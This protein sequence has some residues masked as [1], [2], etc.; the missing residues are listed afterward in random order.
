MT[1]DFRTTKRRWI[2]LYPTESLQG[3]IRYQLT[4][5]ERGVWYD[6][7]CFS[8]LCS[9]SGDISDRDGNPFPTSYIAN[10]LNIQPSLLKNTLDKCKAEGRIKEDDHGLHIV[11][12]ARYQSEYDRQKAFRHKLEYTFEMFCEDYDAL[13][14]HKKT[15]GLGDDLATSRYFWEKYGWSK[16]DMKG[17]RICRLFMATFNVIT[18]KDEKED[19]RV[20]RETLS[21]LQP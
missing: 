2:K 12:W 7:M 11:N 4:S 5:A 8:S 1:Q 13:D 21:T 14:N 17:T 15:G 18:G 6:L 3:S 16:G 20:A 9:N 19:E 10:R